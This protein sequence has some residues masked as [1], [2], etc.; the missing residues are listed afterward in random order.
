LAPFEEALGAAGF[1]PERA[2]SLATLS[3]AAM[4]GLQL[5]LLATGERA[6][7]DAAFREMLRLLAM[8]SPNAPNEST[9]RASKKR[10]RKVAEGRWPNN[11]CGRSREGKE[12]SRLRAGGTSWR[13]AH[14]FSKLRTRCP[15]R[16]SKRSGTQY[17]EVFRSTLQAVG[18]RKLAKDILWAILQLGDGKKFISHDSR[19]YAIVSAD[20]TGSRSRR[21]S[22]TWR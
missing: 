21:A 15:D 3:L 12:A 18:R 2:R 17:M 19:E 5:D 6:R 8:A 13:A 14:I 16:R 4:R 22:L 9:R 10:N 1:P 11:R 7:I 20:R